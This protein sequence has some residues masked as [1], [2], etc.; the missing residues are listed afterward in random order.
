MNYLQTDDRDDYFKSLEIKK[1]FYFAHKPTKLIVKAIDLSSAISELKSWHKIEI[2]KND[3]TGNR[4]IVDKIFDKCYKLVEG[5]D[6]SEGDLFYSDSQ[7]C[8]IKYNSAMIL[9]LH[10]K[11]KQLNK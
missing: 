9:P 2:K 4:R 5:C 7:K 6:I 10:K 1:K 8:T 11:F 3:M